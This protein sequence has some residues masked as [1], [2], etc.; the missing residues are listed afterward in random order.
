MSKSYHVT[1]KE[2]KGKTKAEIDEMFEDTDSVLHELADKSL[3]K[4][5]VKKERKIAKEKR[6]QAIIKH[7]TA[8]AGK[9]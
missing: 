8:I 3:A 7:K 5:A 2:L 6:N 4:E 1:R 9:G